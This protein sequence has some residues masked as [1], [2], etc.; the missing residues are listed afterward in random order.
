MFDTY[1]ADPFSTLQIFIKNTDI[2]KLAII[3]SVIKTFDIKQKKGKSSYFNFSH[4]KRCVAQ[5][6]RLTK[7]VHIAT[8]RRKKATERKHLCFNAVQFMRNECQKQKFMDSKSFLQI[9]NFRLMILPLNFVHMQH[10]Q[11]FRL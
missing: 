2:S 6:Y 9:L 3:T 4:R 11:A 1:V 8:R 7:F 10:S 5:N